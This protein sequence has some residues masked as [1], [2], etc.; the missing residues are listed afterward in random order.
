MPAAETPIARRVLMSDQGHLRY[1]LADLAIPAS[2]TPPR[3]SGRRILR[4]AAGIACGLYAAAL[5][6]TWAVLRWS[7]PGSWPADLFLYGPRWAA[8]L[9][10]I[11]LAI[12]AARWKLGRPSLG[13]A[14]AAAALPGVIGFN[15]PWPSLFARAGGSEFGLRVLTCNVQGRDLRASDLAEFVRKTRPDVVLLQESGPVVVADVLR[16]EG[17]HVRREGEFCLAS[18][19]PIERFEALRRPDKAYRAFAVR[20]SVSG[21]GGPVQVV[22]VHLMTPRVGLEALIHSRLKGLDAFRKVSA[23]QRYESSLLRD[24]VDDCPAPLLVAGDFNLTPEHSLYRRDWKDSINAFSST[25]WGLGHTMFTRQIG[26]RIDHVL[27]GPNCRPERCR[28]GP[29]VGS[30]HRPVVADLTWP[31]PSSP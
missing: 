16:D 4:G 31:V 20:A 5:L 14:L 18:R 27:A 3:R 15:I 21:P 9:P 26:L 28:I 23:V 13:L 2:P 11:P 22:G 6:A 10:L 19:Y 7:P 1:R 30:A 29:D 25:R 12:A 8:A 17:W 24:W